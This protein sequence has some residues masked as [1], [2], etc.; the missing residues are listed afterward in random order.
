MV[1]W[2]RDTDDSPYLEI[3]YKPRPGHAD[4]PASHRYGGF[5]DFRGGGIFSG[6]STI[7]LVLAG[8]IAGRLLA[9]AGLEVLAHTIEI[10]GI[11]VD[12]IPSI[13]EI[14]DHTYQN[15]VR[16][17][18]S[19]AAKKMEA[20]ILEAAN[21]GDSVGGI[22]EG[23]ALNLPTGVGEP[24]YDSLDA[25]LAKLLFNIPGVKAVEFGA[26]SESSRLKGSSNNDEYFVQSGRVA[27]RTN[28]AGGV[29]GGLSTG[30]PIKVRL[31]FKPTS[32]IRKIQ[33]TVNLRRMENETIE[34]GGRHDPCVVP[35]AVPIVKAVISIV[36]ADH[37]VRVGLIPKVLGSKKA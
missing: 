20:A 22:V 27:S 25:D 36:L 12:P 4:Y 29:I 10:A 6:R 35:K 14:R 32:S 34:V 13:D 1:V 3:R 11:R 33:R 8:A 2:N 30:Q 18:N 16:C 9:T 19:A 7:S 31:A 15:A 21:E 37:L 26:G 23:V 17:A 28:R 5:N 24:L